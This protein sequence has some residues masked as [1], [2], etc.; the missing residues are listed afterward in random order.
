MRNTKGK[1]VVVEF[2]KKGT[3]QERILGR[4]AVA[5]FRNRILISSRYLHAESPVESNLNSN[6][7]SI[8]DLQSEN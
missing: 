3:E 5:T 4:S 7:Q 1:G 8:L 2:V 6:N